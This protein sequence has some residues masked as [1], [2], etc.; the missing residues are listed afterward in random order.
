MKRKR[1]LEMQDIQSRI[2]IEEIVTASGS[3]IVPKSK[4]GGQDRGKPAFPRTN[5]ICLG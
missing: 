2:L 4:R 3:L 1:E 5:L